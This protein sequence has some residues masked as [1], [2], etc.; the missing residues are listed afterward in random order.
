M[1]E[2]SK[3]VAKKCNATAAAAAAAAFYSCRNASVGFVD[4]RRNACKGEASS[5]LSRT[6]PPR[7][8]EDHAQQNQ[9]PYSGVPST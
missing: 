3:R 7:S 9:I 5:L 8:D 4:G 1:K 6:H 2:K